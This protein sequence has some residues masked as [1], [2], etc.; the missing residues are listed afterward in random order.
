MSLCIVYNLSLIWNQLPKVVFWYS[1]ICRK[2]RIIQP[3]CSGVISD[4]LDTQFYWS[5]TYGQEIG[6]LSGYYWL[7]GRAEHHMRGL[8][9]RN[10]ILRIAYNI[11][12]SLS[13]WSFPEVISWWR[14][15][16]RVRC[17]DST[18]SIV[19]QASVVSYPVTF[20]EVREVCT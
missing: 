6:L 20:E 9:A 16:E 4:R 18:I 15:D 14:L 2:W 3:L 7:L 5:W 13:T 1:C 19:R 11:L 8:L 17:G 10:K 12:C